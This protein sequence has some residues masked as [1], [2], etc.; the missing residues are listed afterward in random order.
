MN[1]HLAQVNIA[2]KLAPIDDPIM[3]GFVNNLDAINAIADL[4][5]GFVWRM[6][7]EDI[8]EGARVFQND[9]LVINISVWKDLESL[10]NFTYNSGHIEV[11]RRKNEWFDK[12]KFM[13]MA[14]WYVPIGHEPE[15]QEAKDRLD[16]LRKHGETPFSFS[17]KK[18]FSVE[19][20]V[21]YQPK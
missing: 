3:Q 17:F 10:F 6:Q 18:R 16:Y 14:F 7:D 2:K 19:D 13:H 8:E 5:E 12:M 11:F 21:N 9:S 20:F 1:Y 4:S 15:F